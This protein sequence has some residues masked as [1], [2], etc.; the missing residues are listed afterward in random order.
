M[1]NN[2]QA[3]HN[4]KRAGTVVLLE[5]TAVLGKVLTASGDE[6]WAK[7]TDLTE[8]ASGVIEQNKASKKRRGNDRPIASPSSRYRV[9]RAA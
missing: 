2:R 3:T 6:F 9:V 8:L 4:H 5:S 1:K 7:L